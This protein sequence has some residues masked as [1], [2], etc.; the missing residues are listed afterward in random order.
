MSWHYTMSN[1]LLWACV[2]IRGVCIV[3]TPCFLVGGTQASFPRPG[4]LMGIEPLWPVQAYPWP[5]LNPRQAVPSM[6]FAQMPC[7]VLRKPS[8]LKGLP[9]FC[10]LFCSQPLTP[11]LCLFSNL[12]TLAP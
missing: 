6:W 12:L 4:S 8:F 2:L 7:L 11:F 3:T 9:A 10:C 5:F 1:P